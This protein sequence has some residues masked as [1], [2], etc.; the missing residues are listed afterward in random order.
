[1]IALSVLVFISAK[2]NGSALLKYVK[3]KGQWHSN[4]IY[5]SEFNRG[6]VF[7]EP[8][9][10]TFLINHKE[11][12]KKR[13]ALMHEQDVDPARKNIRAHAYKVNF[14]GASTFASL[15][16]ENKFSEYYNYFIGNDESKW[17]A[18]VPLFE[19][20]RYHQLYDGIDMLV[21]SSEERFKYDFI[22]KA[23]A[24]PSA[25]VQEYSGVNE[26]FIE[27]GHLVMETSVGQLRELTPYSY[28]KIGNDLVEV[29]CEF[30]LNNNRVTFF[31]PD[32]WDANYA[33]II[34][35]VLVA[36]TLSG[37][38]GTE[39]YGHSGTY[40]AAGNMYTGAICFGTGYPTGVGSVQQNYAGGWND[41]V[42]S[43]LSPNGST[44]IYATYLG[45]NDDDYPH[46][47]VVSDNDELFV[48][49]SSHST[50]YPTLTTAYST[51]L[52]G[53]YD[54]V[55][56]K[57]NSSGNS[58]L[59]STYIGGSFDDGING[60]SSNYGDTYRGEIIVDGAGNP[61]V[62]SVTSS[63]D[64]PMVGSPYQSSFGGLQ[65]GVVF[66]MN[67]ALSSI[68]WSTFLGGSDYN[69]CYGVR[70]DGAGDAY[71]CG[72]TQDSFL[73]NQGFMGT[74]QGNMDGYVVK[75]T[76]GSSTLSASTYWGTPDED[77][78]FFLDLDLDGDVYIYGHS[79][80][81]TSPVTPGV[82][83]NADAPQ[84]IAKLDPSLS[85]N[86]YSTV[87]GNASTGYY[88][89]IPIAFM[90]DKCEFVYWS[91]H[92]SQS[93]LPVTAS[94]IQTMGGFYLGVLQPDGLGLEYATHYGGSGDHVDGGTSRFDP[95]G[96]VYQAV[97][98]SFGFNTSPGAWSSTYPTG[99]G[100]Y[101][102]G[103]FKIDFQT[104]QVNAD[105]AAQPSASGCAPFTVGFVNLSQGVD[106]LWD[107]NDGTPIDTAFQPTHTF[108]SPGVYNVQ[109]IAI[110]SSACNISDTAYLTITVGSSDPVIADFNHVVD[111][112]NMTVDA[113]NTGTPG[114]F[115]QWDMG[116]FST[117]TTPTVFHTYASAGLYLVQLIV[118]DTVCGT[119]DTISTTIDI[120][121]A[122]IADIEALPDS[123]GC[124]PFD[125]TFVNNS[126]G[127]SYVWDFGDGSPL[128][129]T[130]APT[131]TY[132]SA[133]TFQA[134]LIASDPGTCNLHDT[135]YITI[136]AGSGNPVVADFNH[137]VDC[138][139]MSVD[140]QNTG[141]PGLVYQWDM[142]DFSTYTTPTVFH[143][144]ASAGLY[145]VQL[146]VT[147]T[148]CG[149]ADTIST[150]IDIAEAVIADI[151]ALPDSVGCIPFDITFVN[152]SNG[153]SYVWDFGD[154]S[155]LDTTAA[156]THTYNSAGTF[157]ALLIASDPG[158]CNL[159]DTTYITIVAGSGDPVVADFSYVQNANCELFEVTATNLS[160]GD[161]LSY[162]WDMGDA[163]L[164]TDSNVVHQ[165]S[166]PGTY[167]VTLI[168]HDSVCN[169][170]DTAVK[171]IVLQ[172]SLAV[173]IGEDQIICP[174]DQAVFDAGVSGVSYLWNTG[175]TTATI[176]PQTA[177]MYTVIIYVGV[178]EATDTA[179][180]SFT[181]YSSR[182]YT[183]EICV[184]EQVILDAGEAQNY[185]WVTNESTGQIS[186]DQGGEYWVQYTDDFGCIYED[187]I[188]VVQKEVSTTVFA[189][190]AFSPNAD[191]HN[192][193]W[194]VVGQGVEDYQLRI[195]NR[196][197]ELIWL[198][199]SIDDH[200][201]GTYQGSPLP[202]DVYVYKF[203]YYSAC[204]GSV[205]VEKTGHI[206]ILR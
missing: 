194:K 67:T 73:P 7:L 78:T 66:K 205:F 99:G 107:F 164:Y 195:F 142:G 185:L 75:L 129:T 134:L 84:F 199:T 55:I 145:L 197:G 62:A 163:T 196:W 70:L 68:T 175:D 181:A 127:V 87:I 123:V 143:T 1:M 140:A 80:G 120:A 157:Q 47:L 54:I 30:R 113:Q 187:T 101:D 206:L 90:V 9:G 22:V 15:K 49:G 139:N 188:A 131:H 18:N 45:G 165:Y 86:L 91:G 103:I 158:S 177:G 132:N 38:T 111:C 147:D 152:N 34:D 128:D 170:A 60:F 48:L 10:F 104:S 114:L 183:T 204:A 37:T 12:L 180:L 43:K 115:Y 179:W 97:C 144:Y 56:S 133:G 108:N 39:N 159:H 136:V 23:G 71:V 41:I 141:T 116:D 51:T 21:H 106:Y 61:Y 201:D 40:D 17:A 105:A 36:A 130:A 124:I 53:S 153:V 193:T 148:V 102:V 154:G 176:S 156:P 93:M 33:L 52:N 171:V 198:S 191:G 174:Y 19:K 172:A 69:C 121:E 178:C 190:N 202:I 95:R 149:T 28:Q 162:Q 13:H 96:I 77:Q 92:R 119:A 16:G 117:Y 57:L 42:I 182:S 98:T 189:P 14:I 58:L 137:V 72:S 65:D 50:D 59:G 25:I 88:D 138:V 8:S 83:A 109:L 110:D 150:T 125:I 192:D 155:P 64:F 6:A 11:D 184:G 63:S 161:N 160:T 169:D 200:W 81:G 32:G 82:Y 146:I 26:L 112:I 76:G 44:L 46:S 118:T 31:F 100:G 27:S 89:F 24:D 74:Y 29:A 126:N 168:A 35:P 186:V 79:K 94:A 173:D 167:V 135:T 5:K 85:N 4:V 2:A 203:S 3:N 151:E 122:V 20:V 166:G